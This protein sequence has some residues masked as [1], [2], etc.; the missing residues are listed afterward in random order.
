MQQFVIIGGGVIGSSIAYHLALEGHGKSTSVIEPDPTYEWAATL[1]SSGGVRQLFSVPENVK[2]SQYGLYFYQNFGKI[3]TVG[4]DQPSVSFRPDGYMF[5]A[6]Q[7]KDMQVI[8]SNA[9]TQ[10]ANGANVILLDSAALKQRFPSIRNDDIIGGVLSPDDGTID[11]NAALMGFRRKA[12]SLGVTY[13]KDRVTGFNLENRRIRSLALESGGTIEA[14]IVFN[15]AN[16]W[17][18][19]LC[20]KLGLKLPIEPIKRDNY[21]FE[22]AQKLEHLPRTKDS[23]E[24]SFRPEGKGY[25]VGL[26]NR[27]EPAGFNWKVD[28]DWFENEIWPRLAHRVPAF[29]ALKMRRGWS[30]LYD[31]NRLDSNPVLGPVIGGPSNF[32]IALGFSGHGIQAAP[33]IGRA[34]GELVLKGRYESLDLSRFGHRRIVDNAPVKEVGYTS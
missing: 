30:G 34:M 9:A 10:K 18:P 5:L 14:E 21:F 20:E 27:K 24:V 23:T 7:P 12:I 28:Y 11:P 32:H 16:V 26:T 15:C 22:V 13:V 1:R 6:S 25:T 33:A 29:E 19:G 31:Q 4:G 17:G 8:E 3:M 2:M